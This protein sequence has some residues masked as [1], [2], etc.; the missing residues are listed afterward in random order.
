MQLHGIR[1]LFIT[2]PYNTYT[3]VNCLLSS[4]HHMQVQVIDIKH[5]HWGSC[6]SH[7]TDRNLASPIPHAHAVDLV[8]QVVVYDHSQMM[9]EQAHSS[10]L[11]PHV[12]SV[13][14]CAA[15][16]HALVCW[17][18]P[19]WRETCDRTSKK[20]HTSCQCWNSSVAVRCT[21]V[22][23]GVLCFWKLGDIW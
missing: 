23:H 10:P 20:I 3:H 9:K 18:T 22:P 2:D 5:F 12:R 17:N 19:L 4:I 21:A 6:W 11:P 7:K 1:P 15:S 8:F 14:E 13:L 16:H